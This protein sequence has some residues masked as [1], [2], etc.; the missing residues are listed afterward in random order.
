MGNPRYVKV[1]E[2]IK[3]I[4]A[5]LLERRIKDPRLGFVTITDVRLTGDGREGTVFYTVLGDEQARDDTAAALSSA[6]GLI[7]STVGKQLGMKFTPTIDFVLD[8]VPETAAQITDALARAKA[9]DEAVA[10]QAAT[11]SYAGEADPYKHP[12]EEPS[13][14]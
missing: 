1:A 6:K 9:A 7:R 13:E 11:A 8:A 4:V 5:E 14:D 2:Q 10:A 3:V 12:D